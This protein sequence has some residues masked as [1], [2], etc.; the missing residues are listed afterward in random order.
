MHT[1]TIHTKVSVN[2]Q[3]NNQY[4]IYSNVDRAENVSKDFL[5]LCDTVNVVPE[6]VD[7]SFFYIENYTTQYIFLNDIG[8]VEI[9][10]IETME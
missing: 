7:S 9:T 10:S 5:L 6:N 8:D 2:S 3:D 1:T 4:E